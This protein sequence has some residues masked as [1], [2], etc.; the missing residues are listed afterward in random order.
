MVGRNA[1]L[2]VSPFISSPACY[3]MQHDVTVAS[4]CEDNDV[5]MNPVM[6]IMPEL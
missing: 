3:H 5:I 6:Q 4:K 1:S 2:V